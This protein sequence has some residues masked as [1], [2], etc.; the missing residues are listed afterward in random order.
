MPEACT[1]AD[2]RYTL[3]GGLKMDPTAGIPCTSAFGA[4]SSGSYYVLS[5]AHCEGVTRWHAGEQYGSVTL[6]VYQGRVDAERHF[7]PWPSAWY[8]SAAILIDG[9]VIRPI[10]YHITWVATME[11]TTV[12]MAGARSGTRRGSI[13]SKNYSPGQVPGGNRFLKAD[14]CADTGDSGASIFNTNTAYGIHYGGGPGGCSNNP[15]DYGIFGNIVYA[16]DALG[17]RSLRR[18]D[19]IAR[20]LALGAATLLVAAGC[21]TVQPTH[22]TVPNESSSTAESRAPSASGTVPTTQD[23]AQVA[24]E[25]AIDD[26]RL[27]EVMERHSYRI[28]G[29]RQRSSSEAELFLWFDESVPLEEWPIDLCGAGE[30]R[31]P[32]TGLHFLVDLTAHQVSAVSPVW[33]DGYSCIVS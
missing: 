29:A 24:L 13:E 32:F 12:G 6:Q 19:G 3:R 8:V 5:A 10:Y 15:Y 11:G 33:A 20:V 28:D 21:S 26:G 27:T 22:S 7:R 18:L 2:C 9:S 30:S 17:S 16:K 14:Y 31:G 4:V 25:I 23:L 1:S